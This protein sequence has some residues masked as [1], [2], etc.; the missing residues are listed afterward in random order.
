MEVM[1]DKSVLVGGKFTTVAGVS[2]AFFTRLTQTGA[3]VPG[4]WSENPPGGATGI[5]VYDFEPSP[6]ARFSWAVI[7]PP[8]KAPP[9]DALPV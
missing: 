1:P 4:G 9:T 3:A 8:S 5:A 6:R 7:S 2:H